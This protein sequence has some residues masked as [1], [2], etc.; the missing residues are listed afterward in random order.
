MEGEGRNVGERYIATC[1]I[2]MI[3][4]DIHQH[5]FI[6]A[7]GFSSQ[8]VQEQQSHVNALSDM[9]RDWTQ[10]RQHHII[11]LDRN[12][13]PESRQAYRQAISVWGLMISQYLSRAG[14]VSCDDPSAF[15][16]SQ[17]LYVP[18]VYF[19]HRSEYI[20][21][22]H[23]VPDNIPPAAGQLQIPWRERFTDGFWFRSFEF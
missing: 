9:M 20:A 15:R 18:K 23:A 21:H 17:S 22:P 1:C 5:M 6:A 8:Y 12:L 19:D 2:T 14:V 7:V 11:V 13:L 3:R 10:L 4:D 16:L